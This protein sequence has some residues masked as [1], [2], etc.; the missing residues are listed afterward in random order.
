M[1]GLIF[2]SASYVAS[3]Q[4]WIALNSVSL[5][6]VNKQEVN[7]GYPTVGIRSIVSDSYLPSPTLSLVAKP[8]TTNN[9]IE[10]A[11]NRT[12]EKQPESY[13]ATTPVFNADSVSNSS[14]NKVFVD[15]QSIPT[16]AANRV[17]P[18]IAELEKEVIVEFTADYSDRDIQKALSRLLVQPQYLDANDL[19][20]S[21][22][23]NTRLKPYLYGSALNQYEKPIRYP[24]QA[25]KYA[26]YLVLNNTKTINDEQG[27]FKVVT[28]PLTERK[29][30]GAIQT[31]QAWVN[32][33]AKK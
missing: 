2:L 20:T 30:P 31:Y 11:K 3:F 4:N 23:I 13:I 22:V 10:P 26:E 15:K 32:E 28:I 12:L 5:N 33:Y 19:I 8:L 18:M 1:S 6:N 24:A 7:L 21:N 9:V 16:T 29:L 25:F 14:E 17:L 27:Q